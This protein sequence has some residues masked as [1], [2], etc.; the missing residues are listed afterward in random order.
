MEEAI[1]NP[2]VRR[3][4]KPPIPPWVV[5]AATAPDLQRLRQ[6][7]GLSDD[8][9]EGLYLSRIFRTAPDGRRYRLVGPFMGAPGGHAMGTLSAWAG[10]TSS[11]SGVRAIDSQLRSRDRVAEIRLHRRGHLARLRR[12]G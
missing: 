7:M 9:G 5:M 12:T 6:R 11:L 8:R 3:S 2:P 4:D 10:R 1:V